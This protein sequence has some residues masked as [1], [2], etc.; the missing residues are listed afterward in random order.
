M[1]KNGYHS[2]ETGGIIPE[3][4]RIVRE[5]LD[6]LDDTKTGKV[7]DALQVEVPEFKLNEAKFIA[8]KYGT[9]LYTKYNIVEGAQFIS[10]DDLT[11]LYLNNVWRPNLS[12]T[13][14]AGLPAIETAG[15]VLRPK[16][17]V[18][19]SMRLCPSFDAEEAK[20]IM[21]KILSENVPYNAKVHL[22]GD[23]AGSGWSMKEL[24]PWLMEAIQKAGQD[25]FQKETGSY[26]E[27]GSIPFL[28]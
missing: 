28:K 14:A 11:Q 19:C 4:F 18:R 10:Q 26:G 8:E 17:Q 22:H 2:G 7:C 13:G 16:T 5:L 1:G 27:G 9:S 23:H 12:I 21:N 20:K 15:N 25:F 3:T 24:E 6:R